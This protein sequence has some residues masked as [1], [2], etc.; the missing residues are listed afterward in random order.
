[1]ISVML[2]CILWGYNQFHAPWPPFREALLRPVR[3]E[4]SANF[5]EVLPQGEFA[6]H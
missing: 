4:G 3:Y 5:R 1:M 6:W 2:I